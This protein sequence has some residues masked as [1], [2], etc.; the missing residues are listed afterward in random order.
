[1]DPIL[2]LLIGIAVLIVLIIVL[3]VSAFIAL[4]SSAMLVSLL[5]PGDL[6]GK[7]AR[8]A[9][10]FGEV[11]GSI[12]IVIALAAVIGKCLQD[13]GAAHRIV[14]SL[15]RAFGVER[16]P[17][18]LM[19]SGFVLSIPVF[20]DTVF[21]LLIPLARSL[22]AR[23]G[24]NY[25]FYVMAICS[26]AAI[27]HTLVPPT[28]G[29][30]FIANEF[31][32]DLGLMIGMGLVMAVPAALVGL[33][34]SAFM[35]RRLDVPLRAHADELDLDPLADERLPSLTLSLAPVVLPVLLIAGNTFANAL[36]A[37]QGVLAVMGILGNPNLALLIS[38]AIALSLLMRAR[39][40]SLR[41]LGGKVDQALM[42]AGV[43]IL[44]TAGGGAFGAMLRAAGLQD[45]VA[46]WVD[47]AG[48][49][50]GMSLLVLAFAI[51]ALIKFAQGTS[52]VAMITTAAMFSAMNLTAEMLGFHLV[53][54]ATAVGSGALV[55]TWMNDSGFWIYSKMGGFT[56][57]ETLKTWTVLLACLG[58]TSMLMTLLLAAVLPLV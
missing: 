53:Y 3:R 33:A 22:G 28:P 9:T 25:L 46:G 23:T 8:V 36:G 29:P 10:A 7:I 15:L 45:A 19:S 18:A 1:M 6:A 41:D 34:F 44:V 20:F 11:V 54:L 58:V 48:G 24:R 50:L 21:Y 39:G 16:T 47:A 27:T 55:G 17:L 43:I 4:I 40:L 2:I 30:L 26:G 38:A 35:N 49:G 31:G 13:S 37:P 42:S 56:E 51:T 52:T 32:V 57:T 12:G 5:A 14:R